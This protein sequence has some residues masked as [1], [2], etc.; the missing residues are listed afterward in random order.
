MRQQMR[1]RR[2]RRQEPATFCIVCFCRR[3]PLFLYLD[4]ES[5]L[6]ISPGFFSFPLFLLQRGGGVFCRRRGFFFNFLLMKDT[7]A[8]RLCVTHQ[9]MT[10]LNHQRDG[11]GGQKQ[12]TVRRRR[13]SQQRAL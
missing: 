2:R 8:E 5:L 13:H 6:K 10:T 12:T 4:R 7:R 1:P 9:V 11:K 3:P